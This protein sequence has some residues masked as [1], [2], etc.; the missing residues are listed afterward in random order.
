MMLKEI[1]KKLSITSESD[2]SSS[3]WPQ[4]KQK[5]FFF[6]LFQ[7]FL[8]FLSFTPYRVRPL[9]CS[10]KKGV[11][12]TLCKCTVRIAIAVPMYLYGRG[13]KSQLAAEQKKRKKMQIIKY[14]S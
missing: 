3:S 4:N 7:S 10:A 13:Q 6:H 11:S 12:S 8:Y 1:D 5:D 9:S 14:R 2:P